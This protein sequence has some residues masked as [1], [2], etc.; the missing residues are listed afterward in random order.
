MKEDLQKIFDDY[1]EY[2]EFAQQEP[3][4]EQ[5]MIIKLCERVI[6]LMEQLT[7]TKRQLC[8]LRDSMH[9]L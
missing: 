6:L 5:K 4:I 1:L 9:I 2:L 7:E 3:T 8:G